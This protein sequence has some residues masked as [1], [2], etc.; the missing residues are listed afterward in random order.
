LDVS[1]LIKIALALKGGG[2]MKRALKDVS[3]GFVVVLT[4]L[5][6]IPV[7]YFLVRM[8]KTKVPRSNILEKRR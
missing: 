6:I 1:I 2:K 3:D 5:F 4:V 7:I 8:T